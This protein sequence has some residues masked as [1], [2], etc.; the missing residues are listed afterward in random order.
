[1][2]FEAKRGVELL[3]ECPFS[4]LLRRGEKVCMQVTDAT[5]RTLRPILRKKIVHDSVVYCDCSRA[6]NSMETQEF[7]HFS[8]KKSKLFA[9]LKNHING[10]LNFWNR[11][12][13]HLR[14]F[15]GISKG[16]FWVFLTQCEYRFNKKLTTVPR[17][18]K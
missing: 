2:E 10:T 15:K 4:G 18:S 3:E 6:C 11:A 7:R 9:D 5:S 1:M 14:Q 16:H 17:K 13:K 8:V 12:K